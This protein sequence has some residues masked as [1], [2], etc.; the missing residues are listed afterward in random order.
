MVCLGGTFNRTAPAF[1][2]FNPRFQYS[3]KQTLLNQPKQVTSPIFIVRKQWIWLC[4]RSLEAPITKWGEI[5]GSPFFPA[6]YVPLAPDSGPARCLEM[7]EKY[8]GIPYFDHWPSNVHSFNLRCLLYVIQVIHNVREIDNVKIRC[9]KCTR[10]QAWKT[11]WNGHRY[12]FCVAGGM[13]TEL[14]IM[15]WGRILF[16]ISNRRYG[17]WVFRLLYHGN[18]ASFTQHQMPLSP[19]WNTVDGTAGG[20]MYTNMYKMK[21]S[22][23]NA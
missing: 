11:T 14:A 7:T 10:V 2:D 5:Q 1:S 9:F 15:M 19:T 4:D 23:V 6:G 12:F 16:N 22:K 21:H 3:R 18:N 13:G 20:R 17:I 8:E